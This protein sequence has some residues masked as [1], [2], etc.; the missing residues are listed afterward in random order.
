MASYTKKSE[1][2]DYL[3]EIGFTNVELEN[4]KFVWVGVKKREEVKRQKD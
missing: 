3:K 2:V 1:F 4:I